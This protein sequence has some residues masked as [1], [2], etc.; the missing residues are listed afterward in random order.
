MLTVSTESRT[1]VD[2]LEARPRL[3]VVVPTNHRMPS[4]VFLRLAFHHLLPVSGHLHLN[5]EVSLSVSPKPRAKASLGPPLAPLSLPRTALLLSPL[6]AAPVLNLALI[7]VLLL[8]ASALLRSTILLQVVLASPIPLQ[9]PRIPLS[10]ALIS[11]INLL[12]NPRNHPN[13]PSPSARRPRT[14]HRPLACSVSRTLQTLL[15][16]LQILCKCLPMRSQRQLLPLHH[17]FKAAVSS[18][19]QPLIHSPQS[20][21]QQ[22]AIHSVI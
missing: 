16:V 4:V 13:L 20:R 9:L 7:S 18:G 3:V 11:V 8:V 12:L 6:A 15:P 17:L 21:L 22:L 2:A 1:F 10:P 5:L 14:P 19:N